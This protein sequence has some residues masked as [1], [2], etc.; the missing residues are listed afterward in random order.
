MMQN[1]I[2]HIKCVPYHPASNGLAERI[3]QTLKHALKSA[4]TDSGTIQQK[5]ARFLLAYRN[6]QHSMTNETPAMLFVGR[7]LRTR[8]DLIKPNLNNAIHLK[9]F[10]TLA[11]SHRHPLRE[12]HEGQSVIVRDYRRNNIKW[13][14]GRIVKRT[15]PLAYTVATED[16]DSWRRHVDQIRSATVHSDD[17][18]DEYQTDTTN[19]NNNT[20]ANNTLCFQPNQ[21][22]QWCHSSRVA[23][24][25]MS[26]MPT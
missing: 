5:L 1:G 26:L 3:V 18:V 14:T 24:T 16:G 9:Q 22:Q 7:P 13:A 2:Q 23:R 20:S 10:H 12:F 4:K 19:N 11:D 15:G 17:A 25:R 21:P 8:L 6:A